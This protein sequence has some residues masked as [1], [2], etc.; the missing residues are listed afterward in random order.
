MATYYMRADGVAANK[1]AATSDAAAATSMDV[2]VHNGETFSADDIIVISDA[3]GTYR[4]QLTPPS[5]GSVGQPITYQASGSPILAGS[6]LVTGWT[7]TTSDPGGPTS[8]DLIDDNFDD[9][10]ITDWEAA[11]GN[12]T[13]QNQR[14]E[15]VSESSDAD[16][17][18]KSFTSDTEA[19]AI[20]DIE[21][22]AT[23]AAGNSQGGGLTRMTGF[24]HVLY[25]GFLNNGGTLE[26]QTRY[27]TDGSETS[28][29]AVNANIEVVTGTTYSIVLHWVASTGAGNDDGIVEAWIDGTQVANVSNADTDTMTTDGFLIGHNNNGD[30]RGTTFYDNLQVGTAGSDP[31]PAAANTWEATL[32]TEPNTIVVFDGTLGTKEVSAAALN[33]AGEWF[34]ESNVLTVYS[35]SDPDTAFTSPGVEAAIRN[36][37]IFNDTKDYIDYSG[38]DCRQHNGSVAT[39]SGAL[40]LKHSSNINVDDCNF[41]DNNWAAVFAEGTSIADEVEVS[42]R[43]STFARNVINEVGGGTIKYDFIAGGTISGNSFVDS[44][45]HDIR[46]RNSDDLIVENNT[47]LDPGSAHITLSDSADPGNNKPSNNTVRYNFVDGASRIDPLKAGISL[48]VSGGG[49]EHYYNVSI[50]SNYQG[51]RCQES[52]SGDKWYNNTIYNSADDGFTMTSGCANTEFKNNIIMLSG[53]RHIDIKTGATT[54]HTIDNNLYGDDSATKF[55][56]GGSVSNFASW[57]TNS[58]Q[59][60]NSPTPADPLFVNAASDN[61]QLQ[62]ASPAIDAGVD[63]SLTQDFAG[64]VISGLPDIGAYEFVGAARSPGFQDT[65][66]NRNRRESRFTGAG[67]NDQAYR[68]GDNDSPS[69]DTPDNKSLHRYS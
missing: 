43:N 23:T 55:D 47:G 58:S 1:A 68:L 32:T 61:F 13:A 7:E 67:Y 44:A 46:L 33:A 4:A 50:N 30:F 54:G 66:G 3:G 56:W 16:R 53:V 11:V 9:N 41:Q 42:V 69:V 60:G 25:M 49:N 48:V 31:V 34:W 22:D 29:T 57:K 59:D 64:R 18:R 37:C 24:H 26:F 28:A 12:V 2:T 27:G 10:D 40:T 39:G 63:V 14:V 15:V 36:Y 51:M 6:D 65:S 21:V 62:S 17:V 5:A 19:W 38:L 8:G 35:T 52:V 45:E 20:F